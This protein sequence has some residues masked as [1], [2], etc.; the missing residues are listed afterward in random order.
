[1]LGHLALAAATLLSAASADC[2]FQLD[3]QNVKFDL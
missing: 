1:M 2:V 3:K